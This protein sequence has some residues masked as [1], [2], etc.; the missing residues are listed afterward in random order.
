[1]IILWP[2]TTRLDSFL[3]LCLRFPTYRIYLLGGFSTIIVSHPSCVQWT[4]SSVSLPSFKG[5]VSCPPCMMRLLWIIPRCLYRN[6]HVGNDGASHTLCTTSHPLDWMCTRLSLSHL[7]VS[8]C[9]GSACHGCRRLFEI[10]SSLSR[11][12]GFCEL[13]N[14]CSVPSR[15]ALV[16]CTVRKVVLSLNWRPHSFRS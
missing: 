5:R 14:Y 8:L 7:F 2:M 9:V 12:V 6:I 15:T 3:N 11:Y 16:T 10:A 13:M 4:V 1:M